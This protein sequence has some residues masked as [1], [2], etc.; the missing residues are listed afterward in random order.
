MLRHTLAALGAAIAVAAISAPA[1]AQHDHGGYMMEKPTNC[2]LCQPTIAVEGSALW[3][4]REAFTAMNSDRATGLVR[5]LVEAGTPWSRLGVFGT[6]EF[7]PKEGPSPRVNYGARIWVLPRFSMFNITLGAGG[8]NRIASLGDRNAGQ[9]VVRPW[10][11]AGLEW[12]LPFHE[13]ALYGSAGTAY[14][15]KAATEAQFGIRHPIAPWKV[16]VLP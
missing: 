10:S 5:G 12:T 11:E 7:V 8:T 9:Y 4:E 6:M 13:I 2:T 3:R 15:G 14:M 1:A 16:H